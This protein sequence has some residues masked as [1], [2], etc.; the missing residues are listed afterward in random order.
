MK[1]I[2]ES[3]T[4]LTVLEALSNPYRLRIVAILREKQHY[5]SELARKLGIS[6]PL[7]YMHLRKLED[8]GIVR[9]NLE[10]S[11]SGKAI[12]NYTLIPFDIALS[13][14]LIAQLIQPLPIKKRE[15]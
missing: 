2:N 11:G 14:R 4:L 3:D 6:R 12:K 9:G 8:A 5:V 13:D 7:L 1:C 15:E 10:L